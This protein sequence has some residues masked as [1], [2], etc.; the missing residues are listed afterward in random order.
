MVVTASRLMVLDPTVQ[1][2]P[3]STVMAPR[4]KSLDGMTVGLLANGKRNSDEILRNVYSLLQDMYNF[5]GT[6]ELNKRD[7]SRPAPKHIMDELLQKC[8]IVIT[9][10][11]D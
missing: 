1:A 6:V 5:K 8:D 9:A 2:M 11:G 4:P 7:V 10:I 3:E